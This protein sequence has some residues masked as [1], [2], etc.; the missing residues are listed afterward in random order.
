ML[1]LG[2]GNID[3][4]DLPHRTKMT[5]MIFDAFKKCVEATAEELKQSEGRISFTN[6]LWSDPGLDS[7]LAVT[8]HYFVRDKVTRKL[9]W[10]SGLLAFRY[11]EGSHSGVNLAGN[12]I[13][14]VEEL[15]VLHKVASIFA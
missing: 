5:E 4:K 11:I 14:I 3:D 13:K 12:F 1:Y 8:G 10:R 9:I 7:Y 2:N 6:D 15:G